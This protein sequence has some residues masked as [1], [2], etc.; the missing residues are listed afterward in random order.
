MFQTEVLIKKNNLSLPVQLKN[1]QKIIIESDYP[2]SKGNELQMTHKTNTFA[3]QFQTV[4][5]I[6]KTNAEPKG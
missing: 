4:I 2:N 1:K 5:T 6:T 3:Y